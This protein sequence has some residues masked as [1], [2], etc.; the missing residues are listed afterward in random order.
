MT[1]QIAT[2]AATMS[3]LALFMQADIVVKVVMVGLL[4]ASVWTWAIIVGHGA[5]D[6]FGSGSSGPP[7]AVTNLCQSR[8]A[9][10]QSPRAS[11]TR[12]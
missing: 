10:S 12:A 2:D 5:T 1:P 6:A 7:I 9:A 11:A 4:A 8:P 3:P